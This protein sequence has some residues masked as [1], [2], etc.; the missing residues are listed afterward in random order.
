MSTDIV[1][2]QLKKKK[3]FGG[4]YLQLCCRFKSHPRCNGTNPRHYSIIGNQKSYKLKHGENKKGNFS[5]NYNLRAVTPGL[6][7]T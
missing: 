1:D 5:I 4:R 2:G 3:G 6:P 7:I